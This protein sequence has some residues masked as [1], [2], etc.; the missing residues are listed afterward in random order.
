MFTLDWWHD[1]GEYT[2]IIQSNYGFVKI[3]IQLKNIGRVTHGLTL[4]LQKIRPI[5]ALIK[6]S[7]TGT[8]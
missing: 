7:I 3:R 8:L 2:K 5:V 6:N 1:N 4:T